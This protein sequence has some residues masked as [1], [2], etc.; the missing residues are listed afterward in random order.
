[1]WQTQ[2]IVKYLPRYSTSQGSAENSKMQLLRPILHVLTGQPLFR[3]SSGGMPQSCSLENVSE[4]C[5]KERVWGYID[6]NLNIE[7]ITDISVKSTAGIDRGVL[8]CLG[9]N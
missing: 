1:M 2:A 9:D 3:F 5:L 6:L 8:F 4:S 7:Y